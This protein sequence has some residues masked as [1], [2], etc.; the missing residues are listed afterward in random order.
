MSIIQGVRG[1][2]WAEIDI[3]K[4]EYNFNCVK[5]SIYA[6]T[7]LCC[8][9]KANAYGHGAVTL[10]K[11][12][13]ELGA[14]M[15]AVSNIEEAL[16]LRQSKIQLPIL[17]LGYTPPE[18]AALLSHHNITQ[19]IYSLEYAESLSKA[20][21]A[22]GVSIET[23]IKID[24]GMG[25]IGFV[26]RPESKKGLEEAYQ[27]CCLS[28]LNAKG[29]FTHFAVADSG[30]PGREYTQKQFACFT[31]AIE[32]LNSRGIYFEMRH[33]SNS[34]TIF[35]FPEYQ[36]DMVRA[37][38]V[39]YGLS[40]SECMKNRPT[41]RP[42]MAL[43]SVIS[44][45]KEIDT[46]ETISYGRVFCANRPTRVATLPIGYAD[47]FYRSNSGISIKIA[48]KYAKII[49]RICMDQLMVDVSEIDCKV[50]DI[51][52]IFGDDPYCSAENIAKYNKTI[53]YEIVCSI[54]ERVPRAYVRNKKIIKWQDNICND[55]V[56]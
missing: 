3:N 36:L 25:R 11:L 43:K 45:I 35:D 51:V 49:G 41:L 14:D 44:H 38:I 5:S 27:V 53:N 54:G 24:T 40:P 13:S 7:K 56:L 17:V 4:I 21:S 33:C 9:I 31:N 1:R 50:G 2:T 22:C 34:A 10:G 28:G 42:A 18:C 55:G 26:Y 20:A 32:Q 30:T 46:S 19:C 52:T 6:K 37:G 29:I 15:L 47:G 12:F 39:L 16:Q 23:H 8:V 48:D